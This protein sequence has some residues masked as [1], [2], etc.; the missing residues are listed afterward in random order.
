MKKKE[1]AC[2]KT[3]HRR[4]RIAVVVAKGGKE[5]KQKTEGLGGPVANGKGRWV[6]R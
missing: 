1:N 2:P 6:G 5:Y 3:K 4:V